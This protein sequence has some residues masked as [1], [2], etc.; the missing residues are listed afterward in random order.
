MSDEPGRELN[1]YETPGV[2]ETSPAGE[3]LLTC[4]LPVATA[5]G[6]PG[7]RLAS[8]LGSARGRVRSFIGARLSPLAAVLSLVGGR[9]YARRRAGLRRLAFEKM[10]MSAEAQH[11][12]AVVGVH[13]RYLDGWFGM[14]DVVCTGVAVQLEPLPGGSAPVELA[15]ADPA[16]LERLRAGLPLEVDA[17]PIPPSADGEAIPGWRITDDEQLAGY[18]VRAVVGLLQAGAVRWHA[19]RPPGPSLRTGGGEAAHA[20]SDERVVAAARERLR[21][22]AA[23]LGANA[24]VGLRVS[25]HPIAPRLAE[26]VCLGLAVVVE[27]EP[28]PRPEADPR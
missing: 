11:A 8:G 12:Q 4:A 17:V 1:P 28:G 25:V 16:A 14:S 13:F 10:V 15:A 2:V 20:F 3:G 9:E 24:I 23:R 27:L 18:R 21:D 6:L 5:V 22:D 7:Y 26:A 19:R